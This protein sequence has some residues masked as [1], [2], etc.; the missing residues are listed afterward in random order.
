M[1]KLILILALVASAAFGQARYNYGAFFQDI[2]IANVSNA[3]L[4][5]SIPAN[6]SIAMIRVGMATNSTNVTCTNYISVGISGSSG[7]FIVA[8]QLPG[9]TN[10]LLPT[11]ASNM[12]RTLSTS[13]PTP[14][15]GYVTRLGALDSAIGTWRVFISYVQK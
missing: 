2:N 12:L 14:I 8:N 4:L 1:K 15:Y 11:V 5:G 10:I 9:P 3:I 7:Y 6:A 13:A